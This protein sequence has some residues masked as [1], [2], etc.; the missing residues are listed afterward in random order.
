MLRP[1]L[2]AYGVTLF[3]VFTPLIHLL[4]AIPG[5][6]IGGIVGGIQVGKHPRNPMTAI[7]IGVLLGML[8]T[9]TIVVVGG[10][11]LMLLQ[12]FG[13]LE[14]KQLTDL[15]LLPLLIGGYVMILGTAGAFFGLILAGRDNPTRPDPSR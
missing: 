13:L 1:V 9:L 5:P 4:T 8:M 3:C 6:F 2:I 15:M 11:V 14:D 10:P 7:V 12:A